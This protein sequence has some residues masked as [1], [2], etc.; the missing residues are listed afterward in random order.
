MSQEIMSEEE[1]K[2]CRTIKEMIGGKT[3]ISLRFE[4]NQTASLIAV[5]HER[6]APSSHDG[7]L[8]SQRAVILRLHIPVDKTQMIQFCFEGEFEKPWPFPQNPAAFQVL[9]AV[10]AIYLKTYLLS[11]T[12][13]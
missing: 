1:K 10:V 11:S 9:P 6:Q 2:I 8:A 3:G 5:I 4:S 12:S 7:E 13:E